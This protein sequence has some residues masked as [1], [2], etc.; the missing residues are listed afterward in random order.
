MYMYM[1]YGGLSVRQS[2]FPIGLVTRRRQGY[3]LT[4]RQAS[5]FL[6]TIHGAFVYSSCVL[7]AY[8][9]S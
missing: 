9:S 1:T 5:Q 8:F 2:V 4:L 7:P 6:G 3:V